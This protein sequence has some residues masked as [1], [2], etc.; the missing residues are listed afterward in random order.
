MQNESKSLFL[1]ID[2]FNKNL[3]QHR[4]H[5]EHYQLEKP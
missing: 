1:I 4:P 2:K 5:E 3:I